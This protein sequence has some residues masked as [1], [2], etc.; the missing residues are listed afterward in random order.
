MWR[1]RKEG[2]HHPGKSAK[3]HPRPCCNQHTKITKNVAITKIVATSTLKLRNGN[4]FQFIILSPKNQEPDDFSFL[5]FA[6]FL[7]MLNIQFQHESLDSICSNN[8]DSKHILNS[9]SNILGTNIYSD[10]QSYLFKHSFV[11]NLF[12]QI[13]SDICL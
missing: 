11:S 3:P 5:N 8:S 1:R 12:L 10:I 4:L 7:I 2:R 6:Y 9:N 13:Y